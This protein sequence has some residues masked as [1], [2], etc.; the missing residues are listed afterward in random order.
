MAKIML[1][2]PTMH[3][4]KYIPGYTPL[5]IDDKELA[6]FQAK[7]AWVVSESAAIT[8]TK[9]KTETKKKDGDK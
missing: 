7:G 4:G 6:A 8:E 3:G 9:T 5:D 2:V 1:P